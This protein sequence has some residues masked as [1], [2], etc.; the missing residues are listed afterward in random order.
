MSEVWADRAAAIGAA[1][2][3]LRP[4]VL[5]SLLV[6]SPVCSSV[7]GD[8]R[9]TKISARDPAKHGP[10]PSGS[11]GVRHTLAAAAS[12]AL[13]V[14]A[15]APLELM[16]INLL[17][18]DATL[19]SAARSLSSGWFRGNTAD[20]LAAALRIGITMPAFSWFKTAL[21]RPLVTAGVIDHESA[22]LPGWA[23]FT[24]GALAGCS[25][26]FVCFPFEVARTRL[27][28]ACDLRLGPI[29]CLVSLVREEGVAAMYSGLTA[30]LAGVLPYNAI[31]L[32]A[33]DLLRTQMIERTTAEWRDGAADAAAA[34]SLPLAAVAA[35]GA[36]SGVLAATTCFPLEVVRRRQMTGELLGLNPYVALVRL[37]RT[38]GMQ[39]RAWQRASC[40][41]GSGRQGYG[42]RG[43]T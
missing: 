32:A 17:S 1:M 4:L 19:Q 42:A 37:V 36:A 24:A 27:A 16:R 40:A 13:G 11:N 18:R 34:V 9:A 6:A 5:L 33:Y 12:G 28:V 2:V 8:N 14:T 21:R 29:G 41:L 43:W 35:I 20:V 7:A 3:L 23:V 38:E 10:W 39:V 15:L 22:T 26:S 31:K 25:A 30:T